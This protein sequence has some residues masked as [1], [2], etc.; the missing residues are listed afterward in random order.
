MDGVNYHFRTI[1]DFEKLKAENGVL[2]IND[3]PSPSELEDSFQRSSG[4]FTMSRAEDTAYRLRGT[5]E[6]SGFLHLTTGIVH[7]PDLLSAA[8]QYH[9]TVTAFICAVMAEVIIGKQRNG[10]IGT[11][12]VAFLGRYSR[13]E[14]LAAG[15][16]NFEDE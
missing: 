2:D 14:N 5:P 7:T 8:H 9:A 10:P 16:Y 4:E 6:L 3:P 15:M 1:P 11:V 13:F 12:R